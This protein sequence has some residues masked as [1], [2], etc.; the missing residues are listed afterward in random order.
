MVLSFLVLGALVGTDRRA[1][2]RCMVSN[3]KVFEGDPWRFGPERPT[4]IESVFLKVMPV[5]PVPLEVCLL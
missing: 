4:F 1:V 5:S 3:A 2:R